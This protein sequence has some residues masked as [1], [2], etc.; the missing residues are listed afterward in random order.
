MRKFRVGDVVVLTEYDGFMDAVTRYG[1]SFE[2]CMVPR[3]KL[4]VRES[5]HEGSVRFNE[6]YCIDTDG[7]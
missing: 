7:T 6:F 2:N 1:Y 3:Q 5:N 4:T